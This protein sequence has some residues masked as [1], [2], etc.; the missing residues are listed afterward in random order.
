MAY[1]VIAVL[2]AWV[3]SAPL[4]WAA[5]DAQGQAALAMLRSRQAGMRTVRA[6][7]TQ[8][9]R[10]ELLPRPIKSRGWVVA[11]PPE[12][13]RWEYEDTMSVIYDGS[14]LYVYYF[15]MEQAE[16]IEGASGFVGPLTFSVDE[17]VRRYSVDVTLPDGGGVALVLRPKEGDE[18]PFQTMR[19]V[20]G[21]DDAFPREVTM[22]EASG[23][24]TTI[25]FHGVQV[26]AEVPHD[27]F[28]FA[29]PEGVQVTVRP[30]AA[31]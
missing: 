27:V 1:A 18:A 14:R 7:F 6:E 8:E 22:T 4:A 12:G 23:D 9:K 17:I 16:V 28:V 31:Q 30:R 3:V 21:P 20:F 26:N 25:R 11:R 19:M 13:V 5:P 29:P 2:A 24:R 10:T 15:E